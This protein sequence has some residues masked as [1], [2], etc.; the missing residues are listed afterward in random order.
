[1]IHRYKVY[2]QSES[3]GGQTALSFAHHLPIKAA[4]RKASPKAPIFGAH[5]TQ[6]SI[7]RHLNMMA[8]D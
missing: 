6:L 4:G 8:H 2:T 7:L 3:H 1:M 5:P